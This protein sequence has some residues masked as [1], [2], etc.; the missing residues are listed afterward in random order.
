MKY[1]RLSAR[2]WIWQ[3]N[4][5]ERQRGS[6]RT[7]RRCSQGALAS[8]TCSLVELS[9]LA[10]R[11][12]VFKANILK[13]PFVLLRRGTAASASPLTPT[14]LRARPFLT[15]PTGGMLEER[16]ILLKIHGNKYTPRRYL[17]RVQTRI[18]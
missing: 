8:R 6:L 7:E 13:F 14:C 10:E 5:F 9:R 15:R 3:R 2:P 12:S 18:N 1:I 17:W 16:S 11:N 4:L